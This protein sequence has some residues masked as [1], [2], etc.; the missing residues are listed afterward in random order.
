MSVCSIPGGGGI[1]PCIDERIS[2]SF[3]Y[4]TDSGGTGRSVCGIM[5][6]IRVCPK[7]DKAAPGKEHDYPAATTVANY[8]SNF[9]APQESLG[10]GERQ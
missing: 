8:S 5:A 1:E 4:D 3:A 10:K 6:T 2:L 7:R 9:E